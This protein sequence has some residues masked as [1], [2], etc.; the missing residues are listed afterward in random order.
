MISKKMAARLNQQVNLEFFSSNVYLQMSA[1]AETNSLTGSAAFLKKQAAEEMMHMMKFFDYINQS[2]SMAILGALEA[3]PSSYK[4]IEDLFKKVYTHEQH[5]TKNI[6]EIAEL[7]WK[8]KDLTT[9]NFMQWFITEQHEEETQA[10]GILDKI[11]L[12]GNDKRAL[13]LIDRELGNMAA[14]RPE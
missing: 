9:F 14:A 7:A 2:D 5:V 1:W 11:D 4:S 10:K 13:Y 8:E 12:I 3:P 6:H